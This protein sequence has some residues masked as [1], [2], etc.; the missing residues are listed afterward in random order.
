MSVRPERSHRTAS[1]E[2]K[3]AHRLVALAALGIVLGLAAAY[4]LTPTDWPAS[5]LDAGAVAAATPGSS[6]P[7]G[8]PG[9]RGDPGAGDS[10]A[11]GAPAP[12]TPSAGNAGTAT[13]RPIALGAFIA[14]ASSDSSKIDAYA[15]LTGVMPRIVMWYQAWPG[16]WSAFAPKIADAIRA[17]GA[18]PMVS[19]EPSAGQTKDASWSLATIVDGSHD[20]YI[21]A[22]TRDVAAWGHTI[23]VR[24]MY[25]MNGWWAPWCASVNG[26]SA[27]LFVAAWR[28]LIDI[29][30]AEEAT[31]IRW[32]W[33]PNVD[34]DG[35]GVPFGDLYP[36]DA[37]VDWVALD[38]FNRGTSWSTTQWVEIRRIF[39]GSIARLRQFT[40][41]PLM[42]AETGS[43]EVGGDKAAW[44]SGGFAR[45]P[46]DLPDV[47]AV[48]WFD[49]AE[50]GVGIDWRVNSSAAS[51]AAF[52]AVATSALFSAGLP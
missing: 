32:V 28:H 14:G 26:N 25:E 10:A 47:R 5:P 44:I 29:A 21:E 11:N 42:L 51:L 8:D 22:W 33:S 13:P 4:L 40:T 24:P 36:G 17:R 34:S 19:W 27:P 46:L 16:Q 45:I 7:G 23:Y 2:K 37:Y 43:S 35:L 15:T 20:A 50:T 38:G 18:T 39:S 3:V 48:V 1:G 6:A 52:R 31:N 12:P 49:K 30:R 9:A 41:K